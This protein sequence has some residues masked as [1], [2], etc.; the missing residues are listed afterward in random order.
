[1][2]VTSDTVAEPRRAAV[3]FIFVTVLIDILAFGLII[4]VLPHL[5]ASFVDGNV[6][7]ATTWPVHAHAGGGEYFQ[8]TRLVC[9]RNLLAGGQPGGLGH[10]DRLDC[11]PQ[12]IIP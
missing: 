12:R 7:R 9:R 4:P 1:M 11:N 6:S 2:K 10:T 5:I 8:P 3:A